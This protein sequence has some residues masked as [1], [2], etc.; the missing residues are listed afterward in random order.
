M[1]VGDHEQVSP[2]A[3]GEDFTISRVLQHQYL[4]DFPNTLLYDG[5]LSLYDMSRWT[6]SGMLC[7]TEHFRCV[8]AIIGFSN[9]LS[10]DGKIKPLRDSNS[11]KL[12]AVVPHRIQGTRKGKQKINEEEALEIVSL[13][14]GM[15]EL[16]SYKGR[17]I[18]IISL[19]GD[20]QAK[21]IEFLLR[22]HIPA[23]EIE[24]RKIICGNAA[25]FQGDERDVMLL[26]M[27]DS[28]EGDGPMRKAGEGP[29]ES[30]KKRYNV[31]ASRAQNQMWIV[32]SMDYLTDLKPDDIRRELLE[33]A[34]VEAQKS[35]N[36]S[37][38]YKTDS[39]FE[40]LI[41]DALLKRGYTVKTQYSVGY[42]R[43]DIVVEYEGRKLAIECDG[44]RWHS[45]A[46]KVAEDMA[47][48]AVLERLGWRF[49]RIRGSLYFRDPD[50]A[51]N[52]M[53][54]RLNQLNIRPTVESS[55]EP[56]TNIIHE[57][58]LRI[59]AEFKRKMTENIIYTA[60]FGQVAELP[61]ERGLT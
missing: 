4:E 15:C 3:V 55:A 48:Q 36:E 47:R 30:T 26:S 56:P 12:R 19:L 28:N 29:G 31:A 17:T 61:H 22:K 14:G 52:L 38:E 54:Q 50:A 51:L 23:A 10:Y 5:K 25:Q 46:E 58:L 7:L 39:E 20:E 45:G 49:H 35:V 9:R 33:Y 53:W 8:P 59:S 18:G 57:E 42:Y 34:Y 27:V 13:I 37:S 41:L 44:E 43:I 40:R 1:V 60:A 6:A 21:R 11:S 16:E 24:A 32:H 2:E